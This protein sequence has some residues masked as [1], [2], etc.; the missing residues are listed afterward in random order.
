MLAFGIGAAAPLVALGSLSRTRFVAIRGRLVNAGRY[1]KQMFGLILV[2]TGSLIATGLDK[3]FEAWLL[4]RSP[5]W[6]TQLTTRF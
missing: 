5:D 4:D 1:G 6:L 3:S 2:V